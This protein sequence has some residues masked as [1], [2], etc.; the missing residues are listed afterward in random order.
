MHAHRNMNHNHNTIGVD[1]DKSCVYLLMARWRRV[2]S[3][4]PHGGATLGDSLGYVTQ[5][6]DAP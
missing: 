4:M 2:R 6:I 1:D 5:Y 3:S